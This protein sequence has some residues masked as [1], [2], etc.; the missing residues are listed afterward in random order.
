MRNNYYVYLHKDK[1]GNIFYVGK[2]TGDRAYSKE[3]HKIW[4][5]YVTERL[6]GEYT[7]QILHDGLTESEALEIED[8]KIY[9]YGENLVNWQ[10][11]AREFDY[12]ALE[13]FHELRDK[14]R[15]FV[16]QTKLLEKSN[17]SKAIQRYEKALSVMR[18][19]ESMT[20]EKGLI[21]ELNY[22]PP[23]GEVNI[24]D[25]LTLCLINAKQFESAVRESEK[26]F[27]DFK[28]ARKLG[29]G[30][31]VIARI[32]KVKIKLNAS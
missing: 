13:L 21:A 9:E 24:I 2:G 8:K 16:E 7:V 20:L 15:K 12:D 29:I 17:I 19:Y 14:N 27:S 1:N 26:Y 11:P 10:N 30:K 6:F 3:R 23:S 22:D 5:R 4:Q 31:K 25:R 32:E 18:E 28:G